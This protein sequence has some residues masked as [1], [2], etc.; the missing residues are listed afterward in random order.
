LA[1]ILFDLNTYFYGAKTTRKAL[2][3][4]TLSQTFVFAMTWLISIM[5][6][7][8][9]Y[10]M[11]LRVITGSIIA[12]FVS[13]TIDVNVFS[14]LNTL[15]SNKRLWA[16][17][18]ISNLLSQFIDTFIFSLVVFVGVLSLNQIIVSG[19]LMFLIKILS[20]IVLTP[21]LYLIK[22][23]LGLKRNRIQ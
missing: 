6:G 13:S 3:Y 14:Q 10:H 11:S 9:V 17:V 15:F 20:G 23:L 5:S 7:T 22:S 1:F 2:L 12:F 21:C 18:N 4:I 16:S 8:D 19:A